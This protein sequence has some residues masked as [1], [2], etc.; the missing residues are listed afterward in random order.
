MQ[1]PVDQGPHFSP[2]AWLDMFHQGRHES[3]CDEFLRVLRYFELY[4][5]STVGGDDNARFIDTFVELFLSLLTQPQFTIPPR[6]TWAFIDQNHT[7]ANLAAISRF[8]TTDPFLQPLLAPQS[9]LVKVLALYS[10]R[11]RIEIDRQT[12]FDA[13]PDLASRWYTEYA[14]LFTSVCDPLIAE[15]LR[16][17]F[18]FHHPALVASFKVA[19]VM[20]GSTYVGGGADRAIKPLMN[21]SLQR[22]LHDT[23]PPVRNRPQPHKIAILSATWRDGHSSCRIYRGFFE[24]LRHRYDLTFIHLGEQPAT[25]HMFDRVIS[26]PRLLDPGALAPLLDNDFQMAI[27]PEAAMQL[28]TVL[29]SNWRIAPIQVCLLGQSVS[30]WGSQIDYCISGASCEPH[31]HPEQ[32]YSERLIL[33]P[34]AGVSHEPPSYARVGRE[35]S[36][37]LTI[38]CPWT[39]QKI[40]HV[41]LDTLAK[42]L[43]RL[44]IPLLLRIFLAGST[45]RANDHLL[46]TRRL[47]QALHPHRIEFIPEVPYEVYMRLM[48]QGDF[49][50]DS[51]FFGG[52]NTVSDALHLRSPTI[53]WQ[54]DAWYNRIASEMLRQ[55]G[56]EECIARSESEYIALA[57][58]MI[59]DNA[60]RE[61]LHARLQAADLDATVY[62]PREATHFAAAIDYLMQN[63]ERLRN[64]RDAGATNPIRIT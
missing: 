24:Q 47:S 58:R 3:L 40:H 63:H 37:F 27:F 33:L 15:N 43:A 39:S 57:R 9:D 41:F 1:P 8:G 2:Q 20:Y 4:A 46:V 28:E 64:D 59:T 48:E 35:P 18:H 36:R 7:I 38:N 52:C 22:W 32:N 13:N 61:S 29:L 34:G 14:A 21:A 44:D 5:F 45:K 10:A 17:H 6:H 60:W 12:L 31:D 11:N 55:A 49:T 54:G 19:D 16:K 50:L 56:L 23:L 30:T 25:T 62:S 26:I 42:V 51:Y 53:T